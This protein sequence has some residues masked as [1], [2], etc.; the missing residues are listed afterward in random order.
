M[1]HFSE[2]GWIF[3][4]TSC[5]APMHW[6]KE[7]C[8]RCKGLLVEILVFPLFF[9][10]LIIVWLR[11]LKKT[12]NQKVLFGTSSIISLKTVKSV[13]DSEFDITYFSF[14]NLN[15]QVSNEKS[16]TIENIAPQWIA[17]DYPLLL[18]KYW[19]FLWALDQFHVFFLYFDGGF[20]DRTV[21]YWRLEPIVYQFFGK[22]IALLPYGADVWD[23]RKNTN[24]YQK[25]GHL[26]YDKGYFKE[27]F[28]K[29]KRVYWWCKYAH[30][31]LSPIDYMRY[32][33]RA[34][35][36]MLFGHVLALSDHP[37]R[38][39]LNDEP[40]KILHFANHG[41]RKGS[42][43]I[44]S[45]FDS[46]QDKAQCQ[47]LEGVSRDKALEALQHC[48]IFIDNIIDGFVSYA[49]IEALLAGKIVITNMDKSLNAFYQYLDPEYYDALLAQ[50]PIIN[51]HKENLEEVLQELLL[52]DAASLVQKS[53][54]SRAFA[55]KLIEDDCAM[56][57]KILSNLLE[58]S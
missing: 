36:V 9:I 13:L 24:L 2:R 20:L 23:S 7:L 48:H 44:A 8:Y 6:A 21:L 3:T 14:K 35:V 47:I 15:M 32:I 41:I 5:E 16:V 55:V 38:F 50:C 19:A 4:N 12:P 18:G 42:H 17:N 30:L 54:Q 1:Q 39:S 25:Y 40:L 10:G 43:H 52:L 26:V 34:D 33:P 46:L 28:K 22:K 58:A 57:K 29:E 27:D 45:V 11:S 56:W 31:V 37:Y 51:A 53:E 49:S